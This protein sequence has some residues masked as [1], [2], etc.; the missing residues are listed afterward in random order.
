MYGQPLAVLGKTDD[1]SR[2]KVFIM[3]MNIGVCMVQDIMLDFPVVD[4]TR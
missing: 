3:P 4:V 2:F 1:A